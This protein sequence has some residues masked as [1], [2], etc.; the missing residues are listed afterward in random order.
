MNTAAFKCGITIR[1]QKNCINVTVA[2]LQLSL[3]DVLSTTNLPPFTAIKRADERH[4]NSA[5]M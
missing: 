5:L 1:W 2:A 4:G 3:K